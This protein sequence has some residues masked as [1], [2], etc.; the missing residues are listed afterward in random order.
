MKPPPPPLQ[1]SP[2]YT[3][4]RV[5]AAENAGSENAGPENGGCVVLYS[6]LNEMRSTQVCQTPQ[7]RCPHV[8]Y[9]KKN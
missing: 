8:S 7:L 4:R 9:V 1:T 2:R 5:A 6:Q 3:A